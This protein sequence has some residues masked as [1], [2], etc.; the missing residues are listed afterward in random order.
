MWQ[1]LFRCVESRPVDVVAQFFVVGQVWLKAL[2]NGGDRC[3]QSSAVAARRTSVCGC[4]ASWEARSQL[5]HQGPTPEQ[6]D[7]EH[8]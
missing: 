7:N 5:N 6:V 1:R 4:R 3:G 8:P 2:E